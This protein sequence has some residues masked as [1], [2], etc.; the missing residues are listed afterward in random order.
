MAI[1]F[2]QELCIQKRTVLLPR[3]TRDAEMIA[4][5]IQRMVAARELAASQIESVN[6]GGKPGLAASA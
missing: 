4:K 2:R 1:D 5:S 3:R 6:R